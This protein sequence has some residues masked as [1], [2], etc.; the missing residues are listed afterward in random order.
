MATCAQTPPFSH[1][2]QTHHLLLLSLSYLTIF[3]FSSEFCPFNLLL[4]TH[5]ALLGQF[6]TAILIHNCVRFYR[7][8]A[9]FLF[10]FFTSIH[11]QHLYLIGLFTY[12]SLLSLEF[13]LLEFTHFLLNSTTRNTQD[14]SPSFQRLLQV[15]QLVH[16]P[17]TTT[18]S[19]RPAN[20]F[21]QIIIGKTNYLEMEF[22]GDCS[23]D[24][25]SL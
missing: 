25:P 22:L 2:S 7:S 16:P 8:S 3:L 12:L 9:F 13:S 1:N 6:N 5:S 21:H 4:I 24:C 23:N 14:V 18:T 19:L 17:S 10:F 20:T 11:S 15:L